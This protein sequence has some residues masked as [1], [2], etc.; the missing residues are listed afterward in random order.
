MCGP[1]NAGRFPE[2]AELVEAGILTVCPDAKAVSDWLKREPWKMERRMPFLI[3][4]R[5]AY[6]RLLESCRAIR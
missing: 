3:E 1:K 2:V 6:L 5:Q 4:K